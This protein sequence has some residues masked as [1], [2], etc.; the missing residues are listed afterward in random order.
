MGGRPS[1]G[2][3]VAAV[4]RILLV[5]HG[6]STWNAAGRWQGQADPPLSDLGR[7]QA[8]S[9][10]GTLGA[11][12]GIAS[13][14]LRRAHE[15]ADIMATTLGAGPVVVEPRLRERDAGAFSGLTREEIHRDL[16]GLLPDD[17]CRTGGGELLPPAGW[18]PD[19]ALQARALAGLGALGQR[20]AGQGDSMVITHS[21]LIY[22]LE[23]LLG[24]ERS[25]IANLEGRWFEVDGDRLTL[26]DRVL[27][28]DPAHDRVTS[29]DQL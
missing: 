26:G 5:R 23:T 17:P 20:W 24:A 22:A 13:S 2:R 27:L 9:A 16:P 11:L 25:R 15:T 6:E 10:A 28:L 4:A 19:E 14:D 1:H 7:S 8:R 3:Y 21:G 29:P 18:E 12:A